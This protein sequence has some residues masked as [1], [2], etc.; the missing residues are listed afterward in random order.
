[1][2][3]IASHVIL[4]NL[5]LLVPIV[6]SNIHPVV[7]ACFMGLFY[8]CISTFTVITNLFS[9]EHILLNTISMGLDTSYSI[10]DSPLP[11]QIQ[12]RTYAMVDGM[13]R[14]KF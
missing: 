12:T 13:V 4:V 6:G 3:S 1:M 5:N 7:F 2:S 11:N 8:S 10:L 9:I 14:T